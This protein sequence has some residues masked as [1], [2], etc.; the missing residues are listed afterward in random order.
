MKTTRRKTFQPRSTVLIAAVAMLAGSDFSSVP[1]AAQPDFY[2]NLLNLGVAARNSGD[3]E[4][5]Y[6]D[7]EIACFGLLDRPQRLTECQ[8][9]LAIT[10]DRKQNGEQFS[11]VFARLVELERRFGVYSTYQGNP[12]TRRIFEEAAFRWMEPAR[13]RHLLKIEA[14]PSNNRVPVPPTPT[15]YRDRRALLRQS[16]SKDGQDHAALRNLMLLETAAGR[17]QDAAVPAVR[18]LALEGLDANTYCSAVSV[19]VGGQRCREVA[20]SWRLCTQ[21]PRALEAWKTLRC[22]AQADPDEASD[23][24]DS[25]PAGIQ[26]DPNVATIAAS[27]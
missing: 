4:S 16:I 17:S 14:P 18:L 8:L 21:S 22:I 27:R 5:S 25:L 11:K 10:C 24:F 26:A 13:L 19:L 23:Y 12:G 3:F 6:R 20:R 7:L 9:E 15:S 1:L 2:E